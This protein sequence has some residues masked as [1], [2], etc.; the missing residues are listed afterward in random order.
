LIHADVFEMKRNYSF[1]P[2]VSNEIVG[3]L[4]PEHVV[5]FYIKFA[6]YKNLGSKL[7]TNR[8]LL[9]DVCTASRHEFVSNT[10]CFN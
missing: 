5:N 3:Y 1:L 10:M 6:L 8:L 4:L 7:Y 9:I 2:F